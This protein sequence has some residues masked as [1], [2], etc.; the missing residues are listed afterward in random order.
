MGSTSIRR[1]G[2]IIASLILCSGLAICYTVEAG[3][4][5]P[6]ADFK[7]S[8]LV[9]PELPAAGEKITISATITN[10]ATFDGNYEASLMI[11][12][13]EE[14]RKVVNVPPKAE[15]QITFELT[16][17]NP[18]LYEVDL[19][20]LKGSFTVVQ[21][22]SSGNAGFPVVPVVGALAGVVLVGALIIIWLS[23]K[24][25]TGPQA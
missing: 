2:L 10:T 11:N 6:G 17:P 3:T 19:D 4:T 22:V 14:S 12:G 8:D 21:A 1:W 9:L 7:I 20:G 18:G 5:Q 25:R 13:L 16:L 23:R 24:K 15:R